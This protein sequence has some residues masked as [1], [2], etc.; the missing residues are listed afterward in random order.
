MKTSVLPFLQSLEANNN[1]DWFQENKPRFQAAH[2]AMAGFVEALLQEMTAFDSD[3][4][5]IDARKSVFRIYRDTRFSANK[6]PYKTNFGANLGTGKAGYYL[7]VQ[8]GRSFVAGG[9]YM[10]ENEPLKAIRQEISYQ[11]DAFR[12]ILEAADFRRFF[13]GLSDEGK[14]KR[15]P[16][17]F[18]KDDPMA[19][20]LKLKR[21]VA[22]RP[23]AD[24]E[25]LQQDAVK[26]L[27]VMY[28]ALRPLK[29]FL[30]APLS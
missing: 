24:E 26:N 2:E 18:D 17:G 9:I 12:A 25:L 8:P 11:P 16:Q 1:R 15:V 21:F 3:A 20:Y 6:D 14:L 27:A 19:E 29:D 28:R 5:K 4:A 13:D 23:V 7:H 10:L 22:V 30:N